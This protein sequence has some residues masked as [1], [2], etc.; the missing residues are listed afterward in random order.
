MTS[1]RTL[2]PL[3]RGA[4]VEIDAVAYITDE[5]V[6]SIQ[7]TATPD[8]VYVGDV[9]VY[10]IQVTNM[11]QRATQ[12][13]ITDTVPDKTQYIYGSVSAGGTESNGELR[14]ELLL[15]QPGE[16]A[17]VPPLSVGL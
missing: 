5:P 8:P 4:Q 14:W 16:S 7:K 17:E 6:L 12:L 13:V 15:L 10:T 3:A 2:R 11:G 1:S 9:L